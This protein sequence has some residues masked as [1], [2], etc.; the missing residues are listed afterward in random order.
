MS[1]RAGK[2]FERDLVIAA[3]VHWDLNECRGGGRSQT[4]AV[5]LR[6]DAT[7]EPEGASGGVGRRTRQAGERRKRTKRGM[8]PASSPW[9]QRAKASL[10]LP[11]FRGEREV[12][13]PPKGWVVNCGL[14]LKHRGERLG[15]AREGGG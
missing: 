7:A 14:Q 5:N 15:E 8:H 13:G 10:V 11:L 1:S 3:R 9:Q 2:T 4:L 6:R 12:P